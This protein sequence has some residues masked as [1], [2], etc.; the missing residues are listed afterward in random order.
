MR[1][2]YDLVF[3]AEGPPW[4]APTTGDVGPRSTGSRFVVFLV[5]GSTITQ[6]ENVFG[7]ATF[8]GRRDAYHDRLARA[9]ANHL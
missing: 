6:T 1:H 2:A 7:V 4:A 3:V 9:E 8:I 5:V